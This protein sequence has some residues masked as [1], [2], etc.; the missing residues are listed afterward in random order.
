MND[1][2]HGTQPAH[3]GSSTAAGSMEEVPATLTIKPAELETY[4]QRQHVCVKQV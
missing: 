4:N 3:I 1:V 2:A